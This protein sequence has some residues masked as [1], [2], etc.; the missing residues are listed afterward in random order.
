MNTSPKSTALLVMDM[1][2]MVF[3]NLPQA[4][5]IVKNVAEAIKKARANNIPV[6]YV[7]VG[8]RQGTPEISSNNKIFSAAKQTYANINMDDFLK[9][10]PSIAPLENDIVVTKRRVSAFTGSDLEVVL[11]GSGIT[12]LVL[13]GFATSGVVLS[14]TR[15]AA[16]KDYRITV[17]HDCCAD[18]DDE[19]HRVLATKVLPRQADVI[20]LNNWLA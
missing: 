14:T 7:R 10:E 12:H 18:R 16:D 3:A 15:E 11:R 20:G 2:P 19:V 8:F 9:I 17:L 1:Q 5:V 6:I 4:D 13:T